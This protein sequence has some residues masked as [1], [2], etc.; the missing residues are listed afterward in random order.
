MA[1]KRGEIRLPNWQDVQDDLEY[2]R[3]SIT[4][5]RNQLH[6][7]SQELNSEKRRMWA[8]F[9]RNVLSRGEVCGDS[10]VTLCYHSRIFDA[11]VLMRTLFEL[12]VTIDYTLKNDNLDGYRYWSARQ[13]A[14]LASKL[15]S[16]SNLRRTMTQM[17][18][19]EQ[20][21]WKISFQKMSKPERDWKKPKDQERKACFEELSDAYHSL[22]LQWY[23]VPSAELVHPLFDTGTGDFLMLTG[24]V[25]VTQQ[26]KLEL[27][28]SLY[29]LLHLLLYISTIAA[30]EFVGEHYTKH[31]EQHLSRPN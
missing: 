11:D 9:L 1:G 31:M 24:S 10:I 7:D 2:V 23:D 16:D 3:R 20:N 18:I 12:S 8:T 29:L 6:L 13:R 4:G 19:Q 5:L 14:K 28:I 17:Y 21:R 22:Y 27:L 15:L 26:N 25:E 30:C